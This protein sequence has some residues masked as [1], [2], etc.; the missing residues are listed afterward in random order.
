V[1]DILPFLEVQHSGGVSENLDTYDA[2]LP[3]PYDEPSGTPSDG[4]F[5]IDNRQAFAVFERSAHDWQPNIKVLT[6][7]GGSVLLSG[8]VPGRKNI[9]I[10]VPTAYQPP[11]GAASV[12]PAGC[13]IGSDQ[14]QVDAF[15]GFQLN[16]GDSVTISTEGPVFVGPLAAASSTSYVQYIEEVNPPGGALGNF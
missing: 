15:N 3:V 6:A 7:G 1:T 13:V 11:S 12:T 4:S 9:T 16:G 8:R 10:S 14:G 5:G 2:E